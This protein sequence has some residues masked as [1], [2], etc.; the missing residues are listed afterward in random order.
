[1]L[2]FQYSRYRISL[3]IYL[4]DITQTVLHLLFMMVFSPGDGNLFFKTQ[5]IQLSL[6]TSKPIIHSIHHLKF[7]PQNKAD[8]CY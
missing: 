7:M 3:I 8:L 6:T 5:L 2:D 1:M 4:S